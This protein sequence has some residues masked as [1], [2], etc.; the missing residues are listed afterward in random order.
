MFYP[1]KY[2]VTGVSVKDTAG[3]KKMLAI[4]RTDKIQLLFNTL[5]G[6]YDFS[7]NI[8]E[9]FFIKHIA[10]LK[11]LF[12]YFDIT[13]KTFKDQ[14]FDTRLTEVSIKSYNL[15]GVKNKVNREARS[16]RK[17]STLNFNEEEDI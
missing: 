3:N 8:Y 5:R 16:V 6:D 12:K 1:T 4:N 11:E 17:T 9:D 2:V 7:A 13:E 14:K 10:D 15:T